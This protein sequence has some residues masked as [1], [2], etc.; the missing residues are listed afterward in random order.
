[1]TWAAL[2]LALPGASACLVPSPARQVAAL[3]LA[4]RVTVSPVSSATPLPSPTSTPPPTATPTPLGR[5]PASVQRP[6]IVQIDNAPQARPQSGLGAAHLVFEYVTEGSVTR[7][8]AVY[9]GTPAADAAA[10]AAGALGPLRSARLV[11]IELSRQLQAILAYHGAS[12][13]VQER[14]TAS[15]ID[16]IS[17]Q[18]P[19]ARNLSWRTAGRPAPHNAYTDLAR[20]RAAAAAR[21]MAGQVPAGAPAPDFLRGP[22]PDNVTGTPAGSLTISYGPLQ[23]TA[24]RWDAEQGAYQRFQA[25]APHLDAATGQPLYAAAVVVLV[26]PVVE[27]NI[28]EDILG[29]RSLDHRFGSEGPAFVFREG[30]QFAGRWRRPEPEEGGLG[31]LVLSDGAPLF[32]PPDRSETGGPHYPVWVQLAAPTVPVRVRE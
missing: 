10:S 3:G 18:A 28:I 6:I 4:P 16:A 11:S 5:L 26:V 19:D 32:L 15:G 30:Q 29:S 8:S 14:L 20:L 24:Y 7:F 22:P 27:T 2:L 13:G 23:T 31:R 1:M 12:T 25:G 21:Q 17:F 9:G